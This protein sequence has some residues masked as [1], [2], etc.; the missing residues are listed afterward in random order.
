MDIIDSE[1]IV[2]SF[3]YVIAYLPV[4]LGLTVAVA[5]IGT[6]IGLLA[7]VAEV[8]HL[9]VLDKIARGYVLVCRSLPN[10]V[11]IYL[12]YYGLPILF[13]A[14]QDKTGIHVPYERVPAAAVA[15]FGLSLPTGAYLAESFRAAIQ[16]VPKGQVEAA[17]SIGMSWPDVFRR[18]LFPQAAVFALPLFANQFL[19]TMKSTSIVFVITVIELLGAAKLF[20]EDNSRYFEAYITVSCLYW[21]MGA[22]FETLFFR[23][24]F[25]LS[26]FKRGAAV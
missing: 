17:L 16:S 25:W 8:L 18:I 4:T 20:C 24:E 5:A 26:R 22:A 2:G 12:V 21:A 9:P 13:L 14:L 1:Y 3:L 15:I 19:N 6:V 7:A 10:M 11:L 23:L